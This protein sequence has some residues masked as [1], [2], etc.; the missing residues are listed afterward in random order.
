MQARRRHPRARKPAA[1]G[2]AWPVRSQEVAAREQRDEQSQRAPGGPEPRPPVPADG[3]P[4]PRTD[5]QSPA[6]KRRADV[7]TDA[8]ATT[9]VDAGAGPHVCPGHPRRQ[10]APGQ[11]PSAAVPGPRLDLRPLGPRQGRR[12]VHRTSPGRPPPPPR[13]TDAAKDRF[14]DLKESVH[15]ELLQQLGPQLY[16]ANLTPSELE[17]QG[18]RSSSPTCWPRPTGR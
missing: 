12:R 3:R 2:Q 10:R 5:G 11:T 15:T 14:E 9:D 6:P 8:P 7:P 17:H 18:P 16:D 4:S 1:V 13:R